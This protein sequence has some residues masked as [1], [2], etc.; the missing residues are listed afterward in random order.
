MSKK[1]V[2][3]LIGLFIM[4]IIAGFMEMCSVS[5]ILPFMN[6]VMKPE[7]TMKKWYII[8]LCKSFGV[9]STNKFLILIA[10]LLAT[11]YFVKNCF[12]LLEVYA[13]QRFIGNAMYSVQS[14]CIH[15][16]IY[17]SYEFFMGISSEKILT[18]TGEL[19][20]QLF[21]LLTQLMN[22]C[23]ELVTASM[24]ILTLFIITPKISLVMGACLSML[25]LF[26]AK[27]I[28][29]AIRRAS[30]QASVARS[31]MNK[32]Q[33]QAING[34]KELK[35][36]R[37]E[38]YFLTNFD[39]SARGYAESQRRQTVWANVPRSVIETFTMCGFLVVIAIHISNGNRIGNM[40][41][42]ITAIAM[43][44]VRLLPAANRI[45]TAMGAVAYAGPYLN[46]VLSFIDEAEKERKH[47]SSIHDKDDL[48]FE[49]QIRMNGVKYRYPHT[50]KPVLDG[51]SMTIKKGES[52]GVVGVSGAGK[53]TAID[54]ILG[55]LSPQ[56]G[57]VTV[58]G[59]DISENTFKWFTKVGYIPQDIFL[60][61]DS[62]RRN[63][64]FGIGVKEID[65]ACVWKALD[66]SAL[67]DFVRGLPQGLD[68][69]IGERGIRLSG[70]Q[71]QRLGIARALYRKPEILFLDEAT[72]A[73]DNGTEEAIME[74]VNNLKSKMT[75]II[76]AHRLTTI[77]PCDHVYKVE[78]GMIKK[79]R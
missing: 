22:M 13:Q 2:F 49:K 40:F 50:E 62:I 14:R 75:I 76:I 61:D 53:T 31:G 58:D 17:S 64:A 43:A 66:E 59:I 42:V 19:I 79:E 7:D 60:L 72:S 48:R 37:T 56:A 67:G 15:A 30:K 24:L 55:L 71:R 26:I 45:S 25:L 47:E 41:P 38:E 10:L 69:Q 57:D 74:S 12:I 52:V 20:P 65:D 27:I 23:S 8:K 5:L 44:A 78:N 34:M 70:G 33:L 46:E 4:M 73:L 77:E 9:S 63:V 51:A 29:P 18:I 28:K 6:I 11:I 21:I 3:H 68:S 39:V 54:I 36:M 1:Q 32:W 35:I 16:L